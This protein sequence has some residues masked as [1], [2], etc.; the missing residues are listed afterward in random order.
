MTKIAI[1]EL[2]LHLIAKMDY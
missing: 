2:K 1:R